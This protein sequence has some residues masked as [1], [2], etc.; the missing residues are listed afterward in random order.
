MSKAKLIMEVNVK[1]LFGVDFITSLCRI[2]FKKT[3]RKF[4]IDYV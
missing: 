1:D 4:N 3:N 2:G